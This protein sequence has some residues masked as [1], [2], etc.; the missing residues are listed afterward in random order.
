MAFPANFNINYYRGDTYE[1]R[2]YPKDAS[3]N[4]FPL[5]DYDPVSGVKFTMS[6]QRGESGIVDQLQGYARISSDATYIDCAILPANGLS[7]DFSQS[8]VYDVEIYKAGTPYDLVTTLLTGTIS[9]TE[10]ITGA[11]E[12]ELS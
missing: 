10:Q 7:M 4:Q 6:T 12:A 8:Y 11:L 9:I 3:G 1:F 2:I 5:T